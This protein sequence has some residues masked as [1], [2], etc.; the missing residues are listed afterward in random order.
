MNDVENDNENQAPAAVADL[1]EHKWP[2]WLWISWTRYRNSCKMMMKKRNLSFILAS[3]M[4]ERY[5]M[6]SRVPSTSVLWTHD[7]YMQNRRVWHSWATG[8]QG[9]AVQAYALGAEFWREC[10]N[11]KKTKKELACSQ[12]TALSTN[13]DPYSW[14][15]KA[16]CYNSQIEENIDKLYKTRKTRATPPRS[17]QRPTG[18]IKHMN[19]SLTVELQT[20][21]MKQIEAGYFFMNKL[22]IVHDTAM[23]NGVVHPACVGVCQWLCV[24]VIINYA[25]NAC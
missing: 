17:W 8:K 3:W 24:N 20:L 7:V 25:S 16:L 10:D 11:G 13:I 18:A 23:E 6:I 21:Y 22:Y 19:N 5:Q 4:Q 2:A 12:A 15:W 14:N 1:Q 9:E